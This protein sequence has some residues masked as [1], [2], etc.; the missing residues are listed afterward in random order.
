MADTLDQMTDEARWQLFPV[1]LQ[2]YD[3]VWVERYR[4][5]EAAICE[6]IGAENIARVTHIGSTA[7]PNLIAKPTIDILL[8]LRP[9]A[10]VQIIEQQ[11]LGLGYLLTEQPG[12][13]PPHMTFLKGY[14]PRGFEG[15]AFHLH[16]R[17]RGDWDELY[18]RDYLRDNPQTAARYA[19]IKQEL[20]ERYRHNR[21]AYTAAKTKFVRY[22]TGLA[23]RAYAGRYK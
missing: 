3:P 13:P 10:D 19:E 20:A 17:F 21:D 23:R 18:F 11:I 5:E 22:V 15:Q 7:V 6:T 9:E 1:L 12:N 14:T 2:P 4:Q 8:E 16:V